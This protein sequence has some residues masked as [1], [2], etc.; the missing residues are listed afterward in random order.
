MT[1]TITMA[2][3]ELASIEEYKENF[4][5]SEAL[6]QL[7]SGEL[8][9]WLR[10]L[11]YEREAAAIKTLHSSHGGLFESKSNSEI[12]PEKVKSLCEILGV[13]YSICLSEET[14]ALISENRKV[15]E[16][17]TQNEEI[18]KNADSVA[19][20]QGQLA[21][22]LNKG[23][24]RIVLFKGSFSI[25]ESKKVH[26]YCVGG[27]RINNPYTAEQYSQLG[28]TVE[29]A[30]LPTERDVS[31]D[32]T[33]RTAAEN[34][35]H[36]FFLDEKHSELAIHFH[37][38]L[39]IGGCGYYFN[40]GNPSSSPTF[41]FRS[42]CE[43]AKKEAV[44]RLYDKAKGFLT[45][46]RSS[47]FVK[48]ALEYYGDKA[49]EAFESISRKAESSCAKNGSKE[50]YEKL[51]SLCK[52]ARKRLKEAFTEEMN[53]DY[54]KLYDISYFYD[55]VDIEKNE[56]FDR[57]DVLETIFSHLTDD[58]IEYKYE[59]IYDVAR[60][61]QKDIDSYAETFFKAAHNIYLE[62][63]GEIIEVAEGID[64]SLAESEKKTVYVKPE[65]LFK[66]EG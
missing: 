26:Y 51:S 16:Q 14:K 17:Y 11:Y 31:E 46:D 21:E 49:S 20:N 9:S 19:Q 52:N 2:G 6:N 24:E 27:A 32:G 48:R 39:D 34:N 53:D 65:G 37:K 13:D 10:S 29:G 42:E 56:Y 28:I 38:A 55:L 62:L 22:L 64:M 12:S 33:F 60:D 23:A 45:A 30:D 66:I 44:D 59:G 3:K 36:D 43:K 50:Q 7:E 35:G 8:E 58:R 40:V 15:L 1:N 5:L 41:R 25:P 63:V 18:L 54:Y 61:L 57:S 47:G 4:S